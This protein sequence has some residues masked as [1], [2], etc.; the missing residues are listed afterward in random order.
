M[1][2]ALFLDSAQQAEEAGQAHVRRNAKHVKNNDEKNLKTQKDSRASIIT[3]LK[4]SLRAASDESVVNSLKKTHDYNT[5]CQTSQPI[6]YR[7]L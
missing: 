2:V 4:I 5:A 3:N 1:H 7:N 6:T